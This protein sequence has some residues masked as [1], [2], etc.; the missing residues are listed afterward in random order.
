MK[1]FQ[2][3]AVHQLNQS[4][5]KFLQV[6]GFTLIELL[7]VIAILGILISIS[8]PSY[9]GYVDRQNI[10]LAKADIVG[11]A[12]CIERSYIVS[13]RYPNTLAEAQCEQ[14]DP[15]G[16][17]YNYFNIT[18]AKGKGKLRKDKNLNPINTFY[19]LYSNGKDGRSVSPLTAKHSRDDIVRANDGGFIG[20]ATDF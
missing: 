10:A 9:S 16:N 14:N 17:P 2:K 12:G 19:D 18:T 5:L 8:I 3:V 4:K 13:S 11:I 1:T 7:I 20:L 15:W 6:I